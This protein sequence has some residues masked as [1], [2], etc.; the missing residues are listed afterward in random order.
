MTRVGKCIVGSYGTSHSAGFSGTT[1]NTLSITGEFTL[2][3]LQFN[4][5]MSNSENTA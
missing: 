2:G 4:L 5:V 1:G 3:N